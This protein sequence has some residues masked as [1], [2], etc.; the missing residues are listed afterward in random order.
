MQNEGKKGKRGGNGGKIRVKQSTQYTQGEG[1][2]SG[3]GGVYRD[4]GSTQKAKVKAT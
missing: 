4:T 3:E 1:S 2:T